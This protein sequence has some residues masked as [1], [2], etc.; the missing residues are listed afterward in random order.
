MWTNACWIFYSGPQL[1]C[2]SDWF[3]FLVR[4]II[5]CLMCSVIISHFANIYL[6]FRTNIHK[7]LASGTLRCIHIAV[8]VTPEQLL[9]VFQKNILSLCILFSYWGLILKWWW[10][11]LL[12]FKWSNIKCYLYSKLS[13]KTLVGVFVTEI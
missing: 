3:L 9:V 7:I 10:G 12:T 8:T 1:S 4:W 6:L 2:E 11:K 13:S 5:N